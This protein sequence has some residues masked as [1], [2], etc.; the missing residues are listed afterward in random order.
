MIVGML[1]AGSVIAGDHVNGVDIRRGLRNRL[2]YSHEHEQFLVRR[3]LP[4]TTVG[5]V[6]NIAPFYDIHSWANRSREK[7]SV[8]GGFPRDDITYPTHTGLMVL[9]VQ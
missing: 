8:V 2:E 1:Q 6:R 9:I 5:S 4:P 3:A 7:A